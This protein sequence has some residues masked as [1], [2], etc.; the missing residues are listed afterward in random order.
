[1]FAQVETATRKPARFPTSELSDNF[2]FTTRSVEGKGDLTYW[3]TGSA[4]H[5]LLCQY[6]RSQHA[7]PHIEKWFPFA[8]IH[9]YINE[10][11][12]TNTVT[13]SADKIYRNVSAGS[14]S[15]RECQKGHMMNGAIRFRV[16]H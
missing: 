14:A 8:Q 2:G 3:R 9:D 15:F 7:G 10:D 5:E 11:I 16:Y 1:M 12:H 13:E 4:E 6:C